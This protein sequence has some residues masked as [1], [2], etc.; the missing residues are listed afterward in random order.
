MSSF[1][2][3]SLYELEKKLIEKH[4]K[5]FAG[6]KPRPIVIT[7]EFEG[8][9]AL[10]DKLEIGRLSLESNPTNGEV[11]AL[12]LHELLHYVHPGKGHSIEFL[13]DAWELGILDDYSRHMLIQGANQTWLEGRI[14]YKNN[15]EGEQEFKIR[16]KPSWEGF[17]EFVIDSNRPVGELLRKLRT[18][19][20][21]SINEVAGKIGIS[22]EELKRIEENTELENLYLENDLLKQIFWGIINASEVWGKTNVHAR[23]EQCL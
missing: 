13:E 11:E 12:L 2:E 15:E 19:Y 9:R 18:G 14:F 5:V 1:D 4:P 16:D 3:V 8:G 22:E 10:P 20:Q 21:L 6:I 7:D 23:D 17:S